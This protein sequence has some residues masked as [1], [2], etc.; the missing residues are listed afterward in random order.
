MAIAAQR[1]KYLD[2]ETNLPTFEFTALTN[3]EV[4]NN[5]ETAVSTAMGAA[6]DAGDLLKKVSS[7]VQE[8]QS[9]LANASKEVMSELSSALNQAMAM[10]EKL[11]LPDF[12]KDIF[13]SLKKLDLNGVKDFVKDLFKVGAAFLCNN[14]DFLKMFMLGYAIN[15]NILAGLLVGLLG[16]WLNRFCKS[17]SKEEMDA[18]TPLGKV[19][20]LIPPMGVSL[21]PD[22]AMDKFSSLYTDHIQQSSPL[23][24]SVNPPSHMDFMTGV[25]EGDTAN[26]MKQ[27][28]SSEIST[29]EKKSFLSTI[30]SAISNE[31]GTS[32][33]YQTLLDAKAQVEKLPFVS[34]ERRTNAIKFSNLSDQL[35][36]FAKNIQNVDLIKV[37]TFNM[38]DLE[39][40]LNSKLNDFK[41]SIGSNPEISTR[42]MNSG[43]FKTLDFS[44][45]L[46]SVSAEETNYMSSKP[47]ISTAHRIHDMHPTTS[48]F[49]DEVI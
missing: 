34:T 22:N 18:S 20:K 49:L 39:K 8:L 26:L 23:N 43:S 37:N 12:V 14:L 17:F 15:P 45:I 9:M 30:T 21:T 38:T 44:S 7:S 2:K 5:V 31:P 24:L 46:P 3:N 25:R 41:N 13:S 19:E 47:N 4:Y 16:S 42:S 33:M 48:V 36:S 10:I 40:S 27:L 29:A 11:E 28:R 35:G 32:P 6:K 1:F